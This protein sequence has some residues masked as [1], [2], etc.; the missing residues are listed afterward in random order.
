MFSKELESSIANLFDQAQESNIQYLT[1][2]HL[3]LMV[4]NDYDVIDCI[5]SHDIKIDQLKESLNETIKNNSV[6]K[7]DQ[8]KPVQPTLGFQRV[9]QRSVFHVQSAGKG[10]VKAINIL[11]AIFSEKESNAVFILNKF[12]LS[13][14]DVVTYL[15]HGTPS[16]KPKKE[17]IKEDNQDNS[18]E[19]KIYLDQRKII[20]TQDD[21]DEI[22]NAETQKNCLDTYL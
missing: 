2:E 15:S 12:K 1:V 14:L 3:L 9:L 10:V 7:I 4:L 5:E 13:R 17:E 6:Q 18:Q 21:C 20:N 19:R 8:N 22:N 11:V 16:K